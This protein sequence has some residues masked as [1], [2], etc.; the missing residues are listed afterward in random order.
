MI[1]EFV[2]IVIHHSC[3]HETL[4]PMLTMDYERDYPLHAQEGNKT[5]SVPENC[6]N[7]QAIT[8]RAWERKMERRG[9]AG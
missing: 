3:G 9:V 7:C 6:V 8:Q 2:H 4:R 1:Y 5:I